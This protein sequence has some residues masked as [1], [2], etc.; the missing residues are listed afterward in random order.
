MELK[1]MPIY[2]PKALFP[3]TSTHLCHVWFQSQPVM[4]SMISIVV[5]HVMLNFNSVPSVTDLDMFIFD[6]HLSQIETNPINPNKTLGAFIQAWQ[7]LIKANEALYTTIISIK[8]L[9]DFNWLPLGSCL[10]LITSIQELFEFNQCLLG[11]VQCLVNLLRLLSRTGRGALKLLK[12]L[13]RRCFDAW[14]L[15]II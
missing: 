10:N 6:S 4:S 12:R 1:M 3:F 15:G 2:V 11:A 14:Y 5:N 8:H 9:F 7:R 13:V